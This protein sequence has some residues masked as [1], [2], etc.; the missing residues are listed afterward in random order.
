M[1]ER[2]DITSDRLAG[3]YASLRCDGCGAGLQAMPVTTWA[4][5][6]CGYFCADCLS[7]AMHLTTP[8]A[9]RR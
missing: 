4:K 6:G 1:S 8:C 9:V 3:L 7:K 2:F 5:V